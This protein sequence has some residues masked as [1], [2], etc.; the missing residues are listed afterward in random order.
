L[1][2][3]NSHIAVQK[4]TLRQRADIGELLLISTGREV[5]LLSCSKPV[6]DR[7]PS[8]L[9]LLFAKLRADDNPDQARQS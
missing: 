2:S 3:R 4:C 8:D 9:A 7:P 1:A 5:R 6:D